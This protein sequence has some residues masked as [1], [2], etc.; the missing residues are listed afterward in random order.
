MH[1]SIALRIHIKDYGA[2]YVSLTLDNF[3]AIPFEF[4]PVL[5]TLSHSQNPDN[6][7][8]HVENAHF[9]PP[10]PPRRSTYRISRHRFLKLGSPTRPTFRI[11]T[12]PRSVRPQPTFLLPR[13]LTSYYSLVNAAESRTVTT[14]Y[15][16]YFPPDGMQTTL[17]I[18]C[19]GAQR[20]QECKEQFLVNGRE[21]V[22]GKSSP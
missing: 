7:P 12:L 4:S 6:L 13:Y 18:H 9:L 11:Q 10:P 1:P 15:T 16:D 14:G 21:I 17:T 5:I 8:H 2:I 19:V 22:V 20:I 3:F